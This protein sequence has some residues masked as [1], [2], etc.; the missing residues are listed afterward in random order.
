MLQPSKSLIKMLSKVEQ[1]SDDSERAAAAHSEM[2]KLALEARQVACGR[3]ESATW[4]L[5]WTGGERAGWA[6][7][8]GACARGSV[9]TVLGDGP[10]AQPAFCTHESAEQE[11]AL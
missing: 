6:L 4:A 5:T 7:S 10:G 1:D 2:R 3:C 11:G 8:L 9:L